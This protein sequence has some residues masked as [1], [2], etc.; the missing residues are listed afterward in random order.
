MKKILYYFFLVINIMASIEIKKEQ[1]LKSIKSLKPEVKNLV[2]K[3]D[4]SYDLWEQLRYLYLYCGKT[5][6]LDWCKQFLVG[7]TNY[8][9]S[10]IDS[11]IYRSPW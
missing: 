10:W 9:E 11:M 1:Y 4:N 6:A 5:C 3:L 2:E 8:C 7:L